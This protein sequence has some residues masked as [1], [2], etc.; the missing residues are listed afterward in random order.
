MAQARLKEWGRTEHG[1]DHEHREVVWRGPPDALDCKRNVDR[2]Y[3]IAPDVHFGAH[4]VSLRIGR[5]AQH[6]RSEDGAAKG[7]A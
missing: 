5:A 1:P 2:G 7:L 4:K 3:H 6:C